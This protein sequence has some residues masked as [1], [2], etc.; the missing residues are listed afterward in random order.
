MLFKRSTA[1][2]A[3][4]VTVLA[5]T[6]TTASARS[7]V[8][9]WPTETVY[10]LGPNGDYVSEWMGASAGWTN[11]GGP[12]EDLVGGSAG[13]FEIDETSGDILEYD[14]T[15][16][17]WTDIGGPGG[18]FVESQGHLYGL[19]PDGKYVAEWNGTPHSW[20]IIGGAA[21]N[22]YGGGDGLIAT[23][24]GE[25]YTGSVWYY[26]GTPESWTDIGGTGYSFVVGPH[27]IYRLNYD[28]KSIS[29][30]GGGT[31]WVS[32]GTPSGD[33]VNFDTVGDEGLVI[34]DGQTGDNLRYNDTPG[35]FTEIGN[36]YS[37]TPGPDVESISSIYG[38]KYLDDTLTTVGVYVYS[39]S[40]T[41]WT[42]IGAP[43]SPVI[44]AEE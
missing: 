32:I 12:A 33:P 4:L 41:N 19:G 20:T 36:M 39:G 2:G 24:P 31:T 22:I 35:S 44:A 26:N 30:W 11:I 27:G 8:D 13:L 10:G 18:E 42:L 16:G 29:Q 3:T 34:I 7:I 37:G 17:S 43:F 9:S 5:F 6:A 23:S 25:T 38:V 14:G 1:V 28:A 21:Q 15:P 40:G